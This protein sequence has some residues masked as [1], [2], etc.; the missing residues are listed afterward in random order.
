MDFSSPNHTDWVCESAASPVGAS[1]AEQEDRASSLLE[2]AAS[3]L[4]KKMQDLELKI[5][6]LNLS[7][8][9]PEHWNLVQIVCKLVHTFCIDCTNYLSLP[10]L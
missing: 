8:I 5:P 1:G 9:P 10:V 7:P 6:K 4:V 2:W 3:E